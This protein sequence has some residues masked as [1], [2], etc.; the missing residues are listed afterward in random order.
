MAEQEEQGELA[1]P[2]EQAGPMFSMAAWQRIW[3]FLAY[4]GFIIGGDMLERAGVAPAALRWLY[5]LKIGVVLA[6]LVAFWR[7]YRELS[8]PLPRWSCP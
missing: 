7:Q 5:A 3:P 2:D 8:V 1:A 6:L 4:I